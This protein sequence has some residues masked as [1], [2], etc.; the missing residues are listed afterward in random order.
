MKVVEKIMNKEK[1][2]ENFKQNYYGMGWNK[3]FRS[4]RN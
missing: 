3:Q 1:P 4:Q 2:L